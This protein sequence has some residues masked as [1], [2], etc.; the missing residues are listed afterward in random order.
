MLQPL[1][2]NYSHQF[3]EEAVP[4]HLESV[5][6]EESIEKDRWD[7]G[8][9]S[10]CGYTDTVHDT[11]MTVGSWMHGLF[12]EP[13]EE[14]NMQMKGIGNYFQEASYAVRDFRRGTIE[15][16]EFN[17]KTDDLDL[18]LDIDD[19]DI[20]EDV[21]DEYELPSDDEPSDEEGY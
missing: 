16:G 20:D 3:D 15:K 5:E 2:E 11:L 17:F 1:S 21:S 10:D 13:T 18:D 4:D 6:E 7:E 12:G 19:L 9:R 14:M 8:G